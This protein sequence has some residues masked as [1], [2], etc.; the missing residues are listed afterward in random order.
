MN[1]YAR[2]L[3]AA[4]RA[5]DNASPNESESDYGTDDAQAEVAQTL[6]DMDEVGAVVSDLYDVKA[7]MNWLA[8]N[9]DIPALYLPAFRA[10]DRRV[11]SIWRAVDA[12]EVAHA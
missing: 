6:I 2:Q 12:L 11:T 4:Q 9:V 5:Y 1:A 10:I 7:L 8:H 3:S